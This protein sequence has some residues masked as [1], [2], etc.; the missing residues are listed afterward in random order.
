MS[1]AVID[2]HV[3]SGPP[4]YPPISDYVPVMAE[5]GIAGAVLVQHLGNADNRYLRGVLRSDP[6][7]F[8]G[9][10]IVDR[11]EDAGG[12]LAD[13][14]AGLRVPPTGLPDGSGDAVFDLLDSESAVASV[15]GPFDGVVAGRFA[16]MV[17]ERPRLRVRLE[18]LGWFRYHPGSADIA[19]FD[20]LLALAALP[21]VTIMWSGFFAN[22]A[23]P[24]PYPDAL[25]YLERSLAA[26]GSERIMWS[27]DW[28]RAGLA[29]G[30]YSAAVEL[31]LSHWGLSAAQAADVLGRTAA[32]VFGL[33]ASVTEG[34]SS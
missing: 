12:V 10:A 28:N 16:A 11:V 34:A 1:P 2:A 27:G 8:A 7:R 9:V 30:E 24:Y 20:R 3:H 18:H 33:P 31:A 29:P 26:F 15:T 5:S 19:A 25:P 4:K 23:A 13:G 6:A 17:A 14:F 32:R 22:A 21:N